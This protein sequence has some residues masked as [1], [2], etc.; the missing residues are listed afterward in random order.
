MYGLKKIIIAVNKNRTIYGIDSKKGDII[1]KTSFIKRYV[2][3]DYEIKGFFNIEMRKNDIVHEE[4]ILIYHS[5]I[6]TKL[7]VFTIQPLMGNL[8]YGGTIFMKKVKKII[9]VKIDDQNIEALAIIDQDYNI[10]IYPQELKEIVLQRG[11]SDFFYE[12]QLDQKLIQGYQYQNAKFIKSWNFYL[13]EKET[14]VD[15]Q[16]AYD[17]NAKPKV[18]LFDDSRVI[19]KHIDYNNIAVVTS[20]RSEI[21]NN[22][23]NVNLYVINCKSGRVIYNQYQKNVDVS[24][25]INV[26]FVENGIFVTYMNPSYSIFEIWAIEFYA[27]KIEN[28]FLRM[29]QNYYF[30]TSQYEHFNYLKQ[31]I[32]VVPLEQKYGFPLGIKKVDAV[33][34]KLCITKRN[35]IVITP[36]NQIYSLDRNLISTRRSIKH[37]AQ[38]GNNSSGSISNNSDYTFE[39]T[40]LPPY[41][42]LLPVNNLNTLSYS[43]NLNNLQQLKIYPSNFESTVLFVAFG[44]DMFMSSVAPDR[45]FDMISEDFNYIYVFGSGILAAVAVIVM[46]RYAKRNMFLLIFEDIEAT[47]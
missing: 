3:P 35:L 32:Q 37:Q 24:Q 21:Q 39:S 14:L 36:N 18:A 19:L 17:E 38:Q 23:G 20:S 29:L 46:R 28:S 41:S 26:V 9:K 12:Y 25:P 31:N 22:I 40:Q 1:W 27:N 13:D 11:L 10:H 42:Y 7:F 30:Q 5:Q 8:G 45:T 6:T 15:I 47:I 34:T 44:N 33:Y 43:L 2:K 16:S 4:T